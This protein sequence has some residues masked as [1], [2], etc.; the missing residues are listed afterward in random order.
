MSSII[1]HDMTKTFRQKTIIFSDIDGTFIDE[2]FSIPFSTMF[3]ADVMKRYDIVFVSSRTIS[4]ILQLQKMIGYQMPFIAE[5]GGVIVFP[6][7]FYTPF[8]TQ[9]LQ[10]LNNTVKI[11]EVGGRSSD[12]KSEI[13]SI[14]RSLHVTITT[15]DE[16]SSLEIASIAGYTQ[17]DAELA[18]QR[19]YSVALE[20]K[21]ISS[22]A[23]NTMI[24]HLEKFS[25]TCNSGGLWHIFTKNTN[26]GHA[27]HT[28]LDILQSNHTTIV[29]IGNHHND[30]SMLKEVDLPFVINNKQSGY[31]CDTNNLPNAFFLKTEG[32]F[33]WAEMIGDLLVREL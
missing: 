30:L 15:M 31:F 26:K 10:I 12:F 29:G 32:V 20:A 11:I 8:P 7:P 3:L 13:F 33:G 14:A 23:L 21:S 2:S 16:L 25:I 19:V 1:S 5:N 6:E 22:G 24:Q 9:H 17:H 27:I 28:F 4:E 18:R